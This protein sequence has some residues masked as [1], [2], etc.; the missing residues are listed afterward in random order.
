MQFLEARP[1]SSRRCYR[2]QV[3]DLGTI[4]GLFEHAHELH[5][6]CVR[7]NRW[8]VLPGVQRVRPVAGAP[9]RF[10]AI[11]FNRLDWPAAVVIAASVTRSL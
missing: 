2:R 10:Y 1:V 8:S 7:C 11:R 4:A 6:Y 3:I 9:S 5:A